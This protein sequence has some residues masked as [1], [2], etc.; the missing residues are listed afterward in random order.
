[1]R[2]SWPFPGRPVLRR[3]A[4][5]PLR[6]RTEPCRT[7]SS[8][9]FHL[10]CSNDSHCS[11]RS[12][13]VTELVLW[14]LRETKRAARRWTISTLC[15]Y[16]LMRYGSHTGEQYSS[17]GLTSPLYA[18]SFT[19]VRLIGRFLRR[20]ANCLLALWHVLFMWFAQVRLGRKF[21]AEVGSTIDTLQYLVVE[22]ILVKHLFLLPGDSNRAT[23]SG[24]ERH[25]PLSLPFFKTA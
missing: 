7:L 16:F 20:K 24:I 4:G 15:V 25:A 2:V 6:A 22:R 3:L 17:M 10:R 8:L 21:N 1:M 13:S 12:I 19:W 18:V 11:L 5:E 14:Y 9:A 23:F